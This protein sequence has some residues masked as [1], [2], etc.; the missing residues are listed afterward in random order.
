MDKHTFPNGPTYLNDFLDL[1]G[2]HRPVQNANIEHRL[3]AIETPDEY[4]I[5]FHLKKPFSASTI[6]P[7]CRHT[8]PVPQGQGHRRQVQGARRFHAVRTSSP[9]CS[10]A[11]AST[12]VRNTELGPGDRPEPQGAA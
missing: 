6:S 5:V 2:L 11:R 4:T 8:I 10:L 1:P 9:T 7:C 12:L 3:K